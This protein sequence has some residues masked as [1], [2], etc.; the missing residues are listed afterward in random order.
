MTEKICTSV[1]FCKSELSCTI[2][3]AEKQRN[4]LASR[5]EEESFKAMSE[6]IGV[7]K[8]RAQMDS[9]WFMDKWE[10]VK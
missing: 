4:L 7:E 6:L 3:V 2:K 9:T 5:D 10:E 1:Q 8:L